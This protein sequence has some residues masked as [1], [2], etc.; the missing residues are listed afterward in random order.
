GPTRPA[1][2]G[3]GEIFLVTPSLTNEIGFQC[4]QAFAM[5]GDIAVKCYGFIY[6]FLQLSFV[7]KQ[8]ELRFLAAL[9]L[10]PLLQNSRD[11]KALHPVFCGLAQRR[12]DVSPAFPRRPANVLCGPAKFFDRFKTGRARSS[13]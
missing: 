4:F 7:H 11:T 6:Q 1:A 9:P 5:G 12:A 2:V 3:D 10:A 13:L 8:C